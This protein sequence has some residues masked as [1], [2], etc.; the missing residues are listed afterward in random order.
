[1]AKSSDLFVV[2]DFV[3]SSQ[4]SAKALTHARILLKTDVAKGQPAWTDETIRNAFPPLQSL[5]EMI[6]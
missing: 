4:G 6:V 1:M 3:Q 2:R 5:R